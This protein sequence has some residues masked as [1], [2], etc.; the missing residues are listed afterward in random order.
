MVFNLKSKIGNRK[1]VGISGIAFVIGVPLTAAQA[2]QTKKIPRIGYLS[3]VSASGSAASL[4]AF[5]QGL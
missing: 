2:Q 3:P 1:W 5:R 4:G